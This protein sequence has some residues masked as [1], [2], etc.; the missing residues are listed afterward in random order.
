MESNPLNS[1]TSIL[2]KFK[3]GESAVIQILIKPT[4]QNWHKRGLKIASQM[5]QGENLNEAMANVS[6]GILLKN[7]KEIFFPSKLKEKEIEQAHHLSPI[8]ENIIN[9]LEEKASK[10]G[11]GVNVRVLVSTK[12]KEMASRDLDSIINT[13]TQFNIYEAGNSFNAIIPRNQNRL[14][15]NFIF[16]KFDESKKIILN[17]EELASLFHP[18]LPSLETPNI[19]WMLYKKSAPPANMAQEGIILGKNSYRGA[20]NIIKIKD[21]DRRRH[22]YIAGMTGTGKSVLIANM[23]IQDIKNGH[24]VCVIDPH[25]DLVEDILQRIPKERVNE[26]IVFDP[27]DTSRPLGLNML[28]AK[29]PQEVDFAVQEMIAIWQKMFPPEILGPVFEH[30]MRNNLLTLMADKENSGTLVEIPRL[31]TDP[32]FQKVKVQKV[33]NPQVRLYW[34]KEIAKT[35]DFHKSEMYGY[36]ISKV[37]RFA[38]NEVMRNII[39]QPASSFNFRRIMDERKIL[40]VNLSKGKI[41]EINSNLL[42]LI[43]V[44][45]LQMAALGRANMPLEQRND[46]YLYIDEFQNFITENISTILSEARKY[47][48][49][50]TVAHQYLGQLI[51]G[52]DTKI[53]DA[54]LGTIGTMIV[55]KVGIEDAEI[56][57]KE[58]QPIFSEQDLINI[59]KFNACV[60]L[61]IDNQQ[62]RAF[63]MRTFDLEPGDGK[64]SQKIKE[65]SRMKYGKDKNIVEKEISKLN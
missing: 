60:K 47:R 64:I 59:E 37:G 58:F 29:T 23:A 11:L 54:V 57:V 26:V 32:E 50:L 43:I 35:S 16:R 42:G 27:S 51:K 19:R 41:G 49:N 45:K 36:I 12:S 61:L 62:V 30:H 13:F 46:F 17:T 28:E 21:D 65:S 44:A 20:E 15:S 3:R 40:L 24:G 4:S 22:I 5:Q 56:L 8:E 48:L 31:F 6:Q 25:G 9:N 39:G 53:R 33:Q 7:L 52:Q 14:I 2:S 10:M 1:L 34:E 18:P 55:F 63:N 38:E